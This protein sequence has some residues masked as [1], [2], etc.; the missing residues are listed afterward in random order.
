M[1]ETCAINCNLLFDFYMYGVR[2]STGTPSVRS[3][4]WTLGWKFY[5]LCDKSGIN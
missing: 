4:T 2:G 3:E 1:T 5:R